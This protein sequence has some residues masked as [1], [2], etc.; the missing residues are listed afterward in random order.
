MLISVSRQEAQYDCYRNRSFFFSQRWHYIGRWQRV[1]YYNQ[2]RAAA[3][4]NCINAVNSPRALITDRTAY[5]LVPLVELSS[6][7]SRCC[8][9]RCHGNWW[10]LCRHQWM[11]IIP[12]ATN[13]S[14]SR[15]K[16]MNF[17][18]RLQ[19]IVPELWVTHWTSN[20]Q[21]VHEWIHEYADAEDKIMG[22]T[23]CTVHNCETFM[24]CKKS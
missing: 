21:L 5:E 2:N 19:V 13:R 10:T 14:I 15:R 18:F 6:L 7:C 22:C 11:L 3:H 12:V 20:A 8:R 4:V 17:A 16:L 1:L 9:N 23:H 24:Q